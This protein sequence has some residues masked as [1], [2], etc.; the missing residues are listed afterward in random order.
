MILMGGSD[1]GNVT[2]RIIRALGALDP[3]FTV[4]AIAGYGF[5]NTGNACRDG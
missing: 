5:T 3:D 2:E 1:P 4:T